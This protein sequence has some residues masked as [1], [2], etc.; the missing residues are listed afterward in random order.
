M[1]RRAVAVGLAALVALAVY[2]ALSGRAP[3]PAGV[4]PAPAAPAPAAEQRADVPVV[5]AERADEQAIA[6]GQTL[7]LDAASLQPGRPVRLRLDLEVPS[8]TDDPRPV[9]VLATDGRIFEVQ[10]RLGA[11]RK[12]VSFELDPAFLKPG[13]YVVEVK[14]SELSHLPLRRYVI[15][16][17]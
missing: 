6:S 16:V 5:P 1:R 2:T 14:T 15:E 3:E 7:A 8:R 10:A 13:R 4:A 11:E 12:E 9:R 17:R